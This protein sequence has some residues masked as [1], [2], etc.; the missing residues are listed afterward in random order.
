MKKILFQI[1]IIFF[2]FNLNITYADNKVYFIDI[3]R[4]L[5]NSNFGKSILKKIKILNDNNIKELQENETLLKKIDNSINSK[6][7]IISKEEYNK[8]LNVLKEKIKKYKIIKDKM[9]VNFEKEK[10]RNLKNFFDQVS[11][12]IQDYMNDNSIDILLENKNVFIGKN[13]LDLTEIIIQE[14][15]NKLN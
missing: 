2:F 3:D 9:V 14:I 1:I 11:P 13:N 12:I 15:N 6:K 5:K 7:N 4:V 10:N 8:E